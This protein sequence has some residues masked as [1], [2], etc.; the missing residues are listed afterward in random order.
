MSERN[1]SFSIFFTLLGLGVGTGLLFTGLL[2][3]PQRLQFLYQPRGLGILLGGLSL[4]FFLGISSTTRKHL[5]ALFWD[6]L[7]GSAEPNKQGAFNECVMLATRAREASGQE[8]KL[9]REIKPYLQHETLRLGLDFLMAAY[10]ENLIKETLEHHRDK[11]LWIYRQSAEAA[12]F[13]GRSSVGLGVGAAAIGALRSHLMVSPST[14]PFYMAGIGLPLGLGCLLYAVVFS[15][16]QQKMRYL[17]ADW[18][19]YENLNIMGVILL[20]GRH[21]A[22]YV[23]TILKAYL[24]HQSPVFAPIAQQPAS[25]PVAPFTPAGASPV[26]SASQY[27]TTSP[28]GPAPPAPEASA[29]DFRS[30]LAYEADAGELLSRQQL[31]RF[32]PVKRNLPPS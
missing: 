18:A 14:L 30:A 31:S 2:T 17:E 32:R 5:S 13:L 26:A 24:P 29:E 21:H 8:L 1:F 25:T 28:E 23:E 9:Y 12:Q 4:C 22:H 15:P 19:R 7:T 20:Q 3:S 27:P 16:L 11:R 6:L 10:P